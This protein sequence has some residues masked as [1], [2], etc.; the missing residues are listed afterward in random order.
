MT[1]VSD[2]PDF[3]IFGRHKWSEMDAELPSVVEKQLNDTDKATIREGKD[4]PVER[5]IMQKGLGYEVAGVI[6]V[7]DQAAARCI[8]A[9][10]NMQRAANFLRAAVVVI[11][12]ATLAVV[13]SKSPYHPFVL[14]ACSV[15][16]FIFL[17]FRHSQAGIF[18]N[19]AS[20][21][22]GS[23][24]LKI[25]SGRTDF[26]LGNRDKLSSPIFHHLEAEF[27]VSDQI[28]SWLTQLR[29]LPQN[30]PKEKNLYV[31]HFLLKAP[32][33]SEETQKI[34]K[35]LS[36]SPSPLLQWYQQARTFIEEHTGKIENYRGDLLSRIHYIQ[37]DIDFESTEIQ[38]NLDEVD[39]D[40]YYHYC[41]LAVTG[42]L[43]LHLPSVQTVYKQTNLR[44]DLC[45]KPC[46]IYWEQIQS[47]SSQLTCYLAGLQPTLAH[48][49]WTLEEA[50]KV[51]PWDLQKCW[52]PKNLF[53]KGWLAE[54]K[55]LTPVLGS[56]EQY[57]AFLR[58]VAYS[59]E[60][61]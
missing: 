2:Y 58:R 19:K 8:E 39:E 55:K 15:A 52:E 30:S 33:N 32:F 60:I 47:L 49:N 24:A 37:S 3:F 25:L 4:L 51:P 20:V 31:E 6:L 11:S 48:P 21:R 1:T 40:V 44:L 53:S 46:A 14:L 12:L 9:C 35:T 26:R 34:L 45:E 54:A 13:R 16:G 28:I 27:K 17:S 18:L 61:Q 42:A 41:D 43:S 7:T 50:F 38:G 59:V 10:A 23:C 29:Q 36:V 22:I 5:A 57:Q 56:S